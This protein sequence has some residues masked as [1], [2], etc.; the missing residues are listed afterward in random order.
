[1][2]IIQEKNDMKADSHPILD[3]VPKLCTC[4]VELYVDIL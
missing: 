2:K 4:W 1:M 3:K